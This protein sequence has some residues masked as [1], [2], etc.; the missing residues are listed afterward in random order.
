MNG[1]QLDKVTEEKDLGVWISNDLKESQQCV[2]ACSKATRWRFLATFESCISS[3]PR[4]AGFR[5]A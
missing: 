1:A 3:K 2:Q 5:P 4:A